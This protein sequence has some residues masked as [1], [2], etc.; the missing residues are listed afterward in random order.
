MAKQF[1]AGPG[2]LKS[3]W[4]IFGVLILLPVLSFAQDTREITAIRT[5]YG[6]TKAL[7]ESGQTYTQEITATLLVIPGIGSPI[8]HAV[9]NYAL[10]ES[11]S[12]EADFTLSMAT[13]H[14]QHAG[15]LF[16]EEFLFNTVGD[17]VF[18]YAK[19]GNGDINEPDDTAWNDGE[20]FYFSNG[21]LIR[22]VTG[23]ITTTNTDAETFKKSVLIQAQAKIMRAIGNKLVMPLPV[24]FFE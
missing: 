16:Y 18:Y 19:Q 9:F 21:K 1:T 11:Q 15:R 20:R 4:M 3:F 17:L 5:L 6:E 7:I 23:D 13:Y 22:K 2:T 10:N 12:G 8:Q 24:S 14:Y